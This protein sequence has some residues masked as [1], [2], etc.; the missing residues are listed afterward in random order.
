MKCA[1]CTGITGSERRQYLQELKDFAR[2]SGKLH[3]TDPWLK[4]KELHSDIDEAT[5]LN[6]TDE[7]RLGYFEEAYR[8]IANIIEDLRKRS[9]DSVAVVPM[10]SVFYW[11]SLFKDAVKDEFVE[12]LSPDLFITIVHTMKATKANLDKDPHGR[13]PG[14]TFPEILHWRQREMQETKRWADTAKKQHIVIARNEP[15]ETL[16]GVLFTDKK[17]IYFSYP[18]SYVA[19]GQMNK[20]K[21]LIFKLRD[22][23]YIVFDPG[24]IDDAKYVGAL[25]KD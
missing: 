25:G 2:E 17:R 18:M 6:A 8:D 21:N 4:T 15:I 5:I 1:I 13:F 3:V 10:H 20:A 12:W 11:K 14:I 23:G 9:K 24:S 22:M 16:Y 7:D 19:A